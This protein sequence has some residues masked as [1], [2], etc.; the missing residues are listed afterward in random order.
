MQQY[1]EDSDPYDHLDAFNVQMDLLTTS[2]LA[3]CRAFPTTFSSTPRTWF[4]S[5]L[6]HSIGC[7]EECQ[8]RF[9]NQYRVLRRQLTPPCHLATVFQRSNES[10]KD[11]I[12]RFRCEVSNVEDPSDESILTAIS[13]ALRK[14]SKLCESIYRTPIKDLREFYE[15][16]AKDIR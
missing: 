14:D 1:N 2:S 4:R 9:L 15:R 3:K 7:W 16:V 5:L 10:L 6:P 13:A 8:Q 12:A 11:Y